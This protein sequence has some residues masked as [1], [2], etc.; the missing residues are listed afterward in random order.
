M[1]AETLVADG[2]RIPTNLR[3]L[4]ILEVLGGSDRPMSASEINEH[5]GLPKQTVHR[6]CTTLEREG[7][8][9]R[10]GQTRRFL[11]GDRLKTMGNG[12]LHASHHAIARRQIL[13]DLAAQVRETVN[14]VAPMTDGMSYVDRVETDWMFRIQLPIGT[15]VPFHCTASGKCYMASLPSR[16]RR[17]FVEA[18]TLDQLTEH[19]HTTPD[20]LLAE[21]SEIARR[22][23]S[24]DAEEFMAGMVA[25]AVPVVDHQGRFAAALAFHGPTP[26]LT[27]E[28][29]IEQVHTLQATAAR[30]QA[31]LFG[32]TDNGDAEPATSDLAGH[33]Q[34]T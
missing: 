19:T 27:I 24:L 1:M 17:N 20:G 8:L 29:A 12:L 2:E 30:L 5:L 6:L 10:H 33:T 16:S 13:M 25:V 31:T 3:T 11:P 15:N 7:F 23:Y 14:Y 34:D 22:G 9:V 4:R 28:T 32:G 21:L 18:L 26:R